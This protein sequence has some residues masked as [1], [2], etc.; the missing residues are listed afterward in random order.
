MFI[1]KK[2]NEFS[3]AIKPN[4]NAYC[5][6]QINIVRIIQKINKGITIGPEF[7]IQTQYNQNSSWGF[8]DG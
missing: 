6:N 7:S 4:D 1:S 8:I 5:Q 3:P 2:F